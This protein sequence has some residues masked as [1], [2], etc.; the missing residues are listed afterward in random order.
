MTWPSSDVGTS[1]TDAGTDSPA[2]DRADILDLK[3]KFNQMRGHVTTLAQSFLNRATAALM[4]TDL[5]ATTVG[6]A[7]FTAASA[8]A[9]QDALGAGTAGKT[10]FTSATPKA[11]R[12]AIGAASQLA[13]RAVSKYVANN[14]ATR[15]SAADNALSLIHI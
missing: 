11:A 9:G 6:S 7:V 3:V 1:H 5:G 2:L 10:V 4:R 15:T 12:T 14:W 8:S 13:M